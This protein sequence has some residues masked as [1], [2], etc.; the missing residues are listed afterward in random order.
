MKLML[1]QYQ[2]SS[3]KNEFTIPVIHPTK[4]IDFIFYNGVSFIQDSVLTSHNYGSDHLPVWAE[5]KLNTPYTILK[6]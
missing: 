2:N 1:A 6:P 5:F 3:I 4:R